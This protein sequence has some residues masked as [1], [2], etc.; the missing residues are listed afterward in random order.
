M[1]KA[2]CLTAPSHYLTWW[3]WIT[4]S[5]RHPGRNLMKFN[6]RFRYFHSKKHIWKHC[7]HYFSYS[8]QVPVYCLLLV[9]E[10]TDNSEGVAAYGLC[11]KWP[12]ISNHNNHPHST[13]AYSTYQIQVLWPCSFTWSPSLSRCRCGIH[14]SRHVAPT[15]MSGVWVWRPCRPNW[16]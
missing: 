15:C 16:D 2:C 13:H 6:W 7:L 5:I 8:V 1:V 11:L 9:P 4:W 12:R 14:G 10:W 3:Y